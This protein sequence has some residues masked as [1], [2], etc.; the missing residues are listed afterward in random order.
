MNNSAHLFEI[1]EK[2][3]KLTNLHVQ[4][5]PLRGSRSQLDLPNLLRKGIF[6][7]RISLEWIDIEITIKS[8]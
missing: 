7:Q 8:Y 3:D 5:F 1:C 6:F 4:W 2:L